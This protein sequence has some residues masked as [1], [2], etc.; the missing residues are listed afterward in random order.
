MTPRRFTL[1]ACVLAALALSAS[2][3][4][5]A[6]T[7]A[8][9][10][11]ALPEM[12]EGFHCPV[13]RGAS[14]TQGNNG[15]R[16]HNDEHNRYAWDYNCD[17]GTPIVAARDGVV[18]WCKTDSNIGGDDRK[19]IPDAN[20][21]IIRHSNDRFSEYAHLS[22][23]SV[24]VRP[25]EFVL[26]GELIGYSGNTGYTDGP[27]LHFHVAGKLRGPSVPISFADF[28]G[29]KGVPNETDLHAAPEKPAVPQKTIEDYKKLYRRLLLPEREGWPDV[30]LAVL[31]RYKLQ[32][33]APDYFYHEVVEAA[34]AR[35]LSDT[36]E[37]M[38]D[39]IDETNLIPAEVV[40]LKRCILSLQDVDA[41]ADL[42]KQLQD[43]EKN[44]LADPDEDLPSLEAVKKLVQGML[45]ESEEAVDAAGGF[46]AEASEISKGEL[47]LQAL[48]NLHRVVMANRGAL[49]ARLDRLK[50]ESERGER[51]SHPAIKSDTL[52][53]G[54]K[55][56]A[57]INY[58]AHYF[59]D[60]KEQA[61]ALL[62]S[63]KT[64]HNNILKK[65][66]GR[67][68]DYLK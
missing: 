56:Y 57:L 23:D 66:N 39:L 30:G 46:Y 55:Y 37:M 62:D 67:K 15:S 14:I 2:L 9:F 53:V 3:L 7:D 52:E 68:S 22:K 32:R 65:T 26:R 63:I 21:V 19:F 44:L 20:S 8:Y 31:E 11:V 49:Q 35:F 16:T 38:Q 34:R 25:G 59:P 64:I 43:K 61:D 18:A 51:K 4:A 10:G 33:E 36:T 27:H 29:N 45:A 47:Q 12:D 5:W 40:L 6:K 54:K 17:V 42:Y 13:Q 1:F 60:E 58:W 41:V 28:K 50:D 48:E 24:L